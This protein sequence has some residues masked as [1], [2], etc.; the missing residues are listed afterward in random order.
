MRTTTHHGYLGVSA[1]FYL[2]LAA[3][4]LTACGDSDSGTKPLPVEAGEDAGDDPG[5]DGGDSCS[6]AADGDRCAA[7]RHCI[8]GRCVFN[9]CGD[10]I[11]AAAEA[12][13]DGNEALGDDCDPACRIVPAGCGNGELQDDEEC[14]DGNRHDLDACSTACTSNVCGNG[15]P[16][17]SEECDDGD[18]VNDD[19]CSNTCTENLCRNGRVDPG[20]ECDDGNRVHDD[21]CNNACKTVICG[22]AKQ[23]AP[24][25]CDDGNAVNDDACADACTSNVCGNLRTDPG[26]LCDGDSVGQGCA[27]DCA[28]IEDDKCRECEE[29]HC[30]DYLGVDWLAGCLD[31]HPLPDIVPEV[32]TMFAQDCI[33]TVDCARRAACGFD[34]SE[35]PIACYCGPISTSECGVG[36][37]SPLAPCAD[38]W[39]ASTRGPSHNDVM[40]RS[41]DAAFPS[42]WAYYLLDCDKKFCASECV[43]LD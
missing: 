33:A 34:P 35:T 17:G 40:L 10:G 12:C 29:L 14:D 15:R 42:G 43:N 19:D 26:E 23:E 7:D 1:S 25:E 39:R 30:R 8:E 41:N 24:E 27:D 9:L 6:G 4:L 38:E 16:D 3:L 13:D 32:D 22:N 11:K 28:S 21:E 18:A 31:G 36:P 37:P 5:L 20:E 2:T